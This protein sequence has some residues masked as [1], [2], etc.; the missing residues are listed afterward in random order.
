M[1]TFPQG[2]ASY[3]LSYKEVFNCYFLPLCWKVLLILPTV[4]IIPVVIIGAV[5]AI[6]RII[7]QDLVALFFIM[8]LVCVASPIFI[9]FVL[10][11]H[12]RT[13][14]APLLPKGRTI[15]KWSPY[16]LEVSVEGD[17]RIYFWKDVTPMT[18]T[19]SALLL[20][21]A[22]GCRTGLFPR[23]ASAEQRKSLA[24]AMEMGK[25]SGG[26]TGFGDGG[27]ASGGPVIS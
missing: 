3:K 11:T 14:R 5:L 26:P 24:A 12:Q 7:P 10:W 15:L 4:F 18:A 19:G 27:P 2:E 17:S 21:F 23:H 8:A 1:Q 22:D 25:H 16:S 6:Q 20:R 13:K 9:A